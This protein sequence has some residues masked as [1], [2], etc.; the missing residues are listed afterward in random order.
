MKLVLP[1]L[2]LLFLGFSSAWASTSPTP[3]NS[4]MPAPVSTIPKSLGTV[5]IQFDYLATN[6]Q[7][8]GVVGSNPSSLRVFFP[9]CP[10]GT[11]TV[12]G[13]NPAAL[14]PLDQGPDYA[15]CNCFC[16][17]NCSKFNA[18]TSGLTGGSWY[19]YSAKTTCSATLE[20]WF[21]SSL[22]AMAGSNPG[23]V[24]NY[25][26]PG[27]YYY[28]MVGQCSSN[29][30][31]PEIYTPYTGGWGSSYAIDFLD[32]RILYTPQNPNGFGNCGPPAPR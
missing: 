10:L 5:Q 19:S 20:G 26:K 22:F 21:P 3:S 18:M 15:Y 6:V 24:P 32:C 1:V 16:K 8:M 31:P 27:Q 11:T 25:A 4:V 30:I 17:T 13:I 7:A 9:M 12:A 28:C 29:P 14:P 2:V 23:S